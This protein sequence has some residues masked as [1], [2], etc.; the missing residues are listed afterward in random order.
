[1]NAHLY[2]ASRG[3]RADDGRDPA[4]TGAE[5]ASQPGLPGFIAFRQLAGP[6]GVCLTS[7]R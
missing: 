2:R 5:A 6:A 7:P 1:M 3:G 4:S